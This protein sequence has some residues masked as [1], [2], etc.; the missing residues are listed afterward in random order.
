M[1][2]EKYFYVLDAAE[3]KIKLDF[4][5]VIDASTIQDKV[6]FIKEQ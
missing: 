4:D 2:F 3:Q 1:K 6:A 5:K